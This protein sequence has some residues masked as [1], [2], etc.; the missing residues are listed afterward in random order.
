MQGKYLSTPYA[1]ARQRCVSDPSHTTVAPLN[2]Y[3]FLNTG[4]D[5]L[6]GTPRRRSRFERGLRSALFLSKVRQSSG[7]S[8]NL[9][10]SRDITPIRPHS[11]S[12]R[13]RVPPLAMPMGLS[14]QH[15]NLG[16][17]PPPR[18]DYC[19]TP[20]PRCAALHTAHHARR[21][22]VREGVSRAAGAPRTLVIDLSLTHR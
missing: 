1:C 10:L 21:N 12:H 7:L 19:R 14:N 4:I 13:T 11:L 15:P 20:A 17:N 18:I 16:A 2:T 9:Y 8:F 22:A 3:T 5:N 6:L